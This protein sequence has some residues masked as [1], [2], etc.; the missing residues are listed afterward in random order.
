MRMRVSPHASINVAVPYHAIFMPAIFSHFNRYAAKSQSECQA[1]CIKKP[2]AADGVQCQATE[3][4]P[5]AR[6]R[7]AGGIKLLF[8]NRKA[9]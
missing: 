8:F 6:F 1:I 5:A 4:P 2:P 9:R 3:K 7:A